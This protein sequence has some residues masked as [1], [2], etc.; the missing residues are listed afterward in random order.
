MKPGSRGLGV[1]GALLAGGGARAGPAAVDGLGVADAGR[2]GEH[3][4]AAAAAASGHARPLPRAV[5]RGRHRAPRVSN[6]LALA[7][8]GDVISLLLNIDGRLCVR[9]AAL[10]RPRRGSSAAARARSSFPGRSRCCRSSCMLKA[11]GL[12]NTY[13]GAIVPGWRASSASS[14]CASTRA[15]SPTSCSKPRAWTAPSEFRIFLA[16][17]AAAARAGARRRWR[18]SRSSAAGTTSCGR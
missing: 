18:C 6:S 8:R 7:V 11:L 3:L 12:V 17:V 2:R 16:I 4:S 13:G 15:A 5:R 10:P 14:S 1:N 9:E